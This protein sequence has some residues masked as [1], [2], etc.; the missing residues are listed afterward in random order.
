M[1][2][3]RGDSLHSE[4]DG[5]V[6]PT[7]N[8]DRKITD[9]NHRRGFQRCEIANRCLFGS[10][11]LSRGMI[12]LRK[13]NLVKEFC[14]ELLLGEILEHCLTFKD[15]M[16]GTAGMS[17]SA[18]PDA[19]FNISM[20]SRHEIADLREDENPKV[21]LQNQ[22]GDCELVNLASVSASKEVPT[23]EPSSKPDSCTDDS[24]RALPGSF[25]QISPLKRKNS[26]V[27]LN[28]KGH[29]S[30]ESSGIITRKKKKVEKA[31]KKQKAVSQKKH[32]LTLAVS[33]LP[34]M[35]NAIT[36][37]VSSTG[38]SDWTSENINNRSNDC[39]DPSEQLPGISVFKIPT[40][41]VKSKLV[42]RE[43]PQG[44]DPKLGTKVQ[45]SWDSIS[46]LSFSDC[47]FSPVQYQ[48]P[49]ESPQET[50]VRPTEI[51]PCGNSEM[52]RQTPIP[53]AE[54]IPS[55][56][57]CK[58]KKN[59][60]KIKDAKASVADTRNIGKPSKGKCV[61]E[62]GE[63]KKTRSE[64]SKE[65]ADS[66][67]Q[68]DI[69]DVVKPHKVSNRIKGFRKES[70]DSAKHIDISDVDKS[71][72]VSSRIKERKDFTDRSSRIDISDEV[73][74]SKVSSKIKEHKD[75]VDSSSQMD[76]VKSH[77]INSRIKAIG[78]SEERETMKNL[79][80]IA[81][82][83]MLTCNDVAD[84]YTHK[85]M[86]A[87]DTTLT[88]P[89]GEIQCFVSSSCETLADKTYSK[90]LTRKRHG[91]KKNQALN[92]AMKGNSVASRKSQIT[93]KLPK[94]R[95]IKQSIALMANGNDMSVPNE[96]LTSNSQGDENL[97]NNVLL[98]SKR[99]L[100]DAK[101]TSLRSRSS[102]PIPTSKSQKPSRAS[103]STLNTEDKRPNSTCQRQELEKCVPSEEKKQAEIKLHS[104]HQS[105]LSGSSYRNRSQKVTSADILKQREI[106]V[107]ATEN[108]KIPPL[109]SVC[110]ISV[111]G[112]L[113]DQA[114]LQIMNISSSVKMPERQLR[115]RKVNITLTEHVNDETLETRLP[116]SAHAKVVTQKKRVTKAKAESVQRE[117]A[118][119]QEKIKR[120]TAKKSSCPE[121]AADNGSASK[122][123]QE[124]I[125]RKNSE[126]ITYAMPAEERL[127][128]DKVPAHKK[129]T[130]SQPK[131]CEDTR[132]NAKQ[133]SQKFVGAHCSIAGGIS[134]AVF[135]AVSIGARAF[136]LFVRNG[137][138]WKLNPLNVAEAEKFKKA[139]EEHGFLP[140]HI[141]PH[142]SYLL[143]C[144]SS[145]VDIL[146][147]SRN[148]L[149]HELQ[150]CEMLGLEM[151]N[152][153]PGSACGKGTVD[154]CLMTVA[155]SINLAHEKTKSVKTVIENMCCQG[156]TVGGKFV[157]LKAIIDN[158][159][160][161][162]RVGVCL[163]TCH[164]FAAGF[165]LSSEEG[166][167]KF[168]DSF[169]QIVGL[170]YLCAMHLND[171]KGE[172]GCHL[173]RH[174][175]IGKGHIGLEGFRCLMNDPR[176][177]NIPMVLETPVG[178]Y[179]KEIKILYDL[180]TV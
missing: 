23:F 147:K 156:K 93:E 134:N 158:V 8:A 113:P 177:D 36:E 53:I 130:K 63:V 21:H 25:I 71:C 62:T 120:Q 168:L 50:S 22:L 38:V 47:S 65:Y 142:G 121:V 176:L 44:A 92:D 112:G 72:R 146:Q 9:F 165:D 31:L 86:L 74:S 60:R 139:C 122:V 68:M 162:S 149:V 114:D 73:R 133:A 34:Q 42:D 75:C 157:E 109:Q 123:Q 180:E 77:K 164:A 94:Q 144:G 24:G 154:E 143:N 126:A 148:T 87:E 55:Q 173:D 95:T 116:T 124:K 48:L 119:T 91:I 2:N 150:I 30:V 45:C 105:S 175:N 166:F 26:K 106:V 172:L 70:V 33:D 64:Y 54:S 171:S 99:T 84:V 136:A 6:T 153:H 103:F 152:F 57:N 12:T 137:R 179:T 96:T 76:V 37:C 115:K 5:F 90:L 108:L 83:K 111:C 125:R 131:P 102:L 58:S 41:P 88:M 51:M 80:E 141:L 46:M 20:S 81:R 78:K 138:T 82:D 39:T 118:Q 29:D 132:S 98:Q 101:V 67:S 66:T 129:S 40:V 159:K 100:K 16:C 27:T 135:E 7:N 52:Y 32:N 15:K 128:Q 170:H 169:D 89:Y 10:T 145:D 104:N 69:L 43:I 18:V 97:C 163:D 59:K 19:K 4:T 167:N 140:R 35:N 11:P 28:D 61:V 174:E 79:S 17:D 85:H 178:A 160:D 1:E 13:I 3:N 107:N 14:D 110:D 161:K 155:E 49:P 117:H 127:K 151:Y 56:N